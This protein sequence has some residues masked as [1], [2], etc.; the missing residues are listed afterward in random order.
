MAAL[1]KGGDGRN[2]SS[3]V[4]VK[5]PAKEVPA[6]GDKK[7]KA[8]EGADGKKGGKKSKSDAGKKKGKK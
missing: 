4:S 6:G 7:R 1:A 3:V 5:A 2:L 8:D